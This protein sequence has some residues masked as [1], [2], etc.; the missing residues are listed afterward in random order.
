MYFS[1]CVNGS[2]LTF[3]K[4]LK[5]LSPSPKKMKRRKEMKEG[6]KKSYYW[7]ASRAAIWILF[8]LFFFSIHIKF[9]FVG[10][11][12]VT[13]SALVSI[14]SITSPPTPPRPQATSSAFLPKAR[15]G[16]HGGDRP[17][18][19]GVLFFI[20]LTEVDSAPMIWYIGVGGPRVTFSGLKIESDDES[21]FTLE[22]VGWYFSF[23]FI[24]YTYRRF[25]RLI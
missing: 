12:G 3:K 16:L 11:S 15:R 5:K 4:N 17:W 9:S 19:C 18:A 25:C 7:P 21:L 10:V 22:L 23:Y 1:S 2:K 20:V 8:R 13:C 6:K 14:P 24:Y